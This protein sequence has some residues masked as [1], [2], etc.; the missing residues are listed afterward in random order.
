MKEGHEGRKEGR[1]PKE[2]RKEG[3]E[4]DGPLNQ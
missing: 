2:G 1:T 3:R 4:E